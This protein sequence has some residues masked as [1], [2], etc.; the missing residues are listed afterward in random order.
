MWHSGAGTS[1]PQAC[2]TRDLHD[3]DYH[4]RAGPTCDVYTRVR[5]VIKV[6]GIARPAPQLPHDDTRELTSPHRVRVS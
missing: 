3:V 5:G 2:D 1:T 6:C 4:I